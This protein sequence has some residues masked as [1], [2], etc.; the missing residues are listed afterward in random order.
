M[1][2][3]ALLL[4]LIVSFIG[5][6]TFVL[7]PDKKLRNEQIYQNNLYSSFKSIAINNDGTYKLASETRYEG[8]ILNLLYYN[9]ESDD[10]LSYFINNNTGKMTAFETLLKKDKV[11][12]FKSKEEKLLYLKYPKFIIKGILDSNVS[13]VYRIL[14]NEIIIY[15][16]NVS[17]NPQVDERLFLK[18]NNNEV[19][20]CLNYTH[21]LDEVYENESY[22]SY[23][24]TKKYIAFT[25]DDGPSRANTKDIVDYLSEY[26]YHATFFMLGSFMVN[27]ADIVKYVYDSGNEIGSHT[28]NHKELKRLSMSEVAN[29]INNTNSVYENI[30]DDKLTLIRPP[31]G[32]INDKIKETFDYVYILWNVDTEDWRYKDS[33]YV[34]NYILDHVKDGDIVLMHDIHNT[35]KE[36]VEKVLPELYVRGYRVVSVSEL[37]KIKNFKLEK[38]HSYRSIK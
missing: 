17:T 5:V 20:E 19:S 29:E 3:E 7:T 23:D 9:K 37:A 38:H 27:N 16:K 24:P 2:G 4:L 33:D 18:I 34:Y 28:Y 6:F 13:R 10:Y 35:T 22:L 1:K 32:G 14:D 36:A 12:E 11:S 30:V 21:K 26:N 15:Y 8:N 31:Y 25:F